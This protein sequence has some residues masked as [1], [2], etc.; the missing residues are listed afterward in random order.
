MR[1]TGQA[2]SVA[3]LGGIAASRLGGGGWRQLL[4]GGSPEAAAAFAWGYRAAML[5]GALLA[6]LG[7]WASMTRGEDHSM[8][9]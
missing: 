6:L 1:V 7:A 2:L 8:S 9:K 5:T 3:I 4:H